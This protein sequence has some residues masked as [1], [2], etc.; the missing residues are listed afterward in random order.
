[1]RRALI[2]SVLALALGLSGC[3]YSVYEEPNVTHV[4]QMQGG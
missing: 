3:A 1:M 2:A 4:G